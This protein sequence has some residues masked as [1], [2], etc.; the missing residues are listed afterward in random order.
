MD[1]CAHAPTPQLQSPSPL[2]PS[3]PVSAKSS[4]K[5]PTQQC[6]QVES[7]SQ[8]KTLNRRLKCKL[9]GD[10]WCQVRPL[11]QG[12]C[13]KH[14]H[15][16]TLLNIP[17]VVSVAATQNQH[18]H[19][20]VAIDSHN[21]LFNSHKLMVKPQPLVPCLASTEQQPFNT[22]TQLPVTVMEM[23]RVHSPP[24]RMLTL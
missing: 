4:A 6:R 20:S 12:C 2:Y 24:Q 1:N 23:P 18:K 10:S 14:K 8:V 21:S 11:A 19:D 9:S 17:P 13:H 7:T 16:P 3:L 5:P 22:K 15:L